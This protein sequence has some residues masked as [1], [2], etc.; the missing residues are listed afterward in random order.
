MVFFFGE[1]ERL[2]VIRHIL[3]RVCHSAHAAH[4]STGPTS[5][6]RSSVDASY[7]NRWSASTRA[8]AR[9]PHASSMGRS[10]PPLTFASFL[11]ASPLSETPT[12]AM[13]LVRTWKR[14]SAKERGYEMFECKLQSW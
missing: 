9:D 11:H 10:I 7:L 4:N 5:A 1:H 3:D 6:R 2:Q 13:V 14:A 12:T 8:A